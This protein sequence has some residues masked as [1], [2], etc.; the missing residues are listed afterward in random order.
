MDAVKAPEENSNGGKTVSPHEEIVLESRISDILR[1]VGMPAN[2]L[3]YNYTRQAI[4]IATRD[5]EAIRYLTKWIYP[6]IAKK[7]ASTSSRVERAIRHAIE[8]AWTRGSMELFDSVLGYSVG[9]QYGRPT[10]GEFIALVADILRLE[11][12]GG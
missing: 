12:K 3:G 6:E 2:F 7:F 5:A 10:N 8:T 4:M 9:R 11:M 1:E